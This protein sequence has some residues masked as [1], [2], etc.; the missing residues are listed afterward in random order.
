MVRSTDQEM[1]DIEEIVYYSQFS[2]GAGTLGHTGKHQVSQEA[3]GKGEVVGRRFYCEKEQVR[4][5]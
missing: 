3:E 1:T 2:G 4:Q 5:A